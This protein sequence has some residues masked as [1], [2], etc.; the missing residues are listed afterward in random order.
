MD[1]LILF[2]LMFFLV[3]LG[4]L[5]ISSDRPFLASGESVVAV[6]CLLLAGTGVFETSRVNV[7]ANVCVAGV[8]EA[9]PDWADMSNGALLDAVE[10]YEIPVTVM[11]LGGAIRAAKS[12]CF[13][14]LQ[15][16]TLEDADG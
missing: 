15:D 6:F 3:A 2:T 1:V 14:R 5:W 8:Q 9:H 13:N 7:V 10:A 4:F 11:T 16:R 12:S